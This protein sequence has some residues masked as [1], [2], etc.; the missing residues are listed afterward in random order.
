MAS[1]A[2]SGAYASS[3]AAAA[4]VSNKAGRLV[5]VIVTVAGSAGTLTI[6]DN[7]AAATGTVLFAA[8]GTTAQGTIFTIDAP[9]FLG[10]FVTPG[11]GQTVLVVWD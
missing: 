8:P 3:V 11:T 10:L 4:P 5:R 9:N 6:N 7:A 2:S 1:P